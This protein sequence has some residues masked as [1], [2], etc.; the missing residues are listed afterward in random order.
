MTSTKKGQS[1]MMIPAALPRRQSA[2]EMDHN[3]DIRELI[4]NM[5]KTL[6]DK[7]DNMGLKI[8]QNSKLIEQNSKIIT[9]LSGQIKDLTIKNMETEKSVAEVNTKVMKQEEMMKDITKKI[10]QENRDLKKYQ[11]TTNVGMS[12]LKQA[13]ED[14]LDQ[15]AILEMYQRELI[16]R[17]RGVPEVQGEDIMS[18]LIKE[19][20]EW[21]GVR[22]EELIMDVDKI[23]RVRPEGKKQYRGPGD[24]LVYLNSRLLKDKILQKRR[25][26]I[27][28]NNV[29]IYKE[30]PKRILK[31]R[32]KYKVLTDAL[33]LKGIRFKWLVPEGLSFTIKDTRKVIRSVD[34]ME[35]VRRTYRKELGE[36]GDSEREEEEGVGEEEA[37]RLGVTT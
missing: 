17:F 3:A 14:I 25:L 24:C 8:E 18:K 16:L 32:E 36:E 5:N 19:L 9:D 6:N 29:I 23:F 7:L 2:P 21:L 26:R 34:V 37:E 13:Q 4:I 15:I 31:K 35:K 11:D 22:E 1:Q 33:K 30:I 28:G 27:D 12:Q 20:A 10:Q